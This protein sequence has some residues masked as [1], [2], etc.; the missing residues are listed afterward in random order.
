M[1]SPGAQAPVRPATAARHTPRPPRSPD[2]PRPV[3]P[4]SSGTGRRHAQHVFPVDLVVQRVEA[5]SPAIPSLWRV[6][7][8]AASEPFRSCLGSSQSPC[9]SL[10]L[11][12][13]LELRP[14]PS[15]GI[16]RLHRYYE[17]LRHPQRARPVPH[18]RPVD[19]PDLAPPGF[20]CCVRFPCVHAVANTPAGPGPS[21]FAHS[22]QPCSLPR[23][24]CR[25]GSRIV[26][27]EACSAFTRVTACS[28]ALPP[29]RG[30]FSEGFSRFVTSLA[31]PIATGWSVSPGGACTHWKAPPL[32]G[33]RQMRAFATLIRSA[34]DLHLQDK[35]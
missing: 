27:F 2:R 19:V 7:P 4:D 8:S 22:S 31:A 15:T 1:F 26:L 16:T 23:N 20:P 34:P 9:P 6:T 3:R 29:I 30:R 11:A 13:I 24:G 21:R 32:H 17:P 10:L 5:D 33:A 25:V 35:L 18:G 12:L 28:L 14:L